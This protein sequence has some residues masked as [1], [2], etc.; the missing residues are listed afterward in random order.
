M[1][2]ALSPLLLGVVSGGTTAQAG[3][4]S[5]G[6]VLMVSCNRLLVSAVPVKGTSSITIDSVTSRGIDVYP[7]IFSRAPLDVTVNIVGTTDVYRANYPAFAWATA[8]ENAD[9]SVVIGPDVTLRSDQLFAA[10]WLRNEVSGNLSVNNAGTVIAKG[11]EQ[12][13]ISLTTHI[14][15]VS[16]IN[17]GKVTATRGRGLYAD[18]NYA[19]TDPVTVSIVNSGEVVSSLA[20]ARAINYNGLA[21]IDNS[22]TVESKYRQAL[23]AWSASGPASIANSGTVTAKDDS[24]VVA[25]TETGDATIINSGT[26]IARDDS[27]HADL[28]DGGHH[29]LY[30]K[31]WTAG[32]TTIENQLGGIVQADQTGI[33]AT[34]ASGAITITQAGSV[35]GAQGIVASTGSGAVTVT[36]S[37]T[38]TAT[39]IGVSFDGTTNSLVNSGTIT[40]NSATDAA[41]VTGN[42]NSTIVN[43]GVIANTGGGAAILFG[44]GTNRLV[45]D[46]IN[47]NIQGVVQAGTGDN[48]LV[49]DSATAASLAM[50]SFGPTGQFRDFDFIEKTGT[51]ALTLSGNGSGFT[52]TM[53]VKDGKLVV[54]SDSGTSAVTVYSGASLSGSGTVG[55]TDMQ[56][57]STI[58]PGNSPGTLT[59]AGNYHQASGATYQAELVPGSTVSD[60]IAVSGKATIDN[61]AILNV[62]RYG[63]GSYVPDARYTVLSANGGVSGTYTLTGDT[64]VSAFYALMATYDPTHV[65]VD[66]VQI[67]AFADAAATANQRAA[68]NGL[69]SVPV[70]NGLRTAVSSL[71]SDSAARTAFDQVSGEAYASAKT[72]LLDDSRFVR[73]ATTQQVQ[74]A[75]RGPDTS[76]WT[77]G[78]GSWATTDGNGNAAGVRRSTGGVLFGADGDVLDGVRLGLVGGYGHTSISLDGGRGSVSGDT[79]SIGAYGGGNLNA[80]ALSLGVNHA[81]HDLTSNRNVAL[82]GFADRMMADYNART[83]QVYGDIGYDVE[84]GRAA[85]QPFA[86]FAYVNLATSGFTEKGGAAALTSASDTIDA[87]FTTL[88]LRA[89]GAFDVG[90]TVLTANGMVGWRHTL[91]HVTPTATNAF[92]G[93]G[94]FTVSGVPLAQDVAVF[95]AGLGTAL[96]PTTAISVNYSGQVGTGISDQ[97]VRANLRVTF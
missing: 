44:N 68:A 95:E 63:A 12:D 36:N 61:G 69:Q 91:N 96:T 81:W 38:I 76:V 49:L 66:A 24:G 11:V 65:Y 20:G 82:S 57:G 73:E 46:A 80:F 13:G 64:Y 42:G 54:N 10:V 85:L 79:Y 75:R 31:I 23:V 21:S 87:A 18:G 29:G 41:I 43:S 35:T 94:A 1:T 14:G 71:T 40:T 16:L 97:G 50:L 37:G 27:S 26:V 9:L 77:R 6:D 53:L 45:V 30:T 2:T 39:G 78:Y 4:T 8:R 56:S 58:S 88:G 34:S 83:T 86:G 60:K 28:G 70:G 17:S 33:L 5:S 62:T 74:S 47:P 55:T 90:T 48:T 93:G 15:N 22:G 67:R 7:T 25:W 52:G 72:A 3:C 19:G 89:K 59:V 84:L 51:G 32:V 92:A